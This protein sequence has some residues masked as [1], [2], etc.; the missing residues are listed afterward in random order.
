MVKKNLIVVFVVMMFFFSGCSPRGNLQD[1]YQNYIAPIKDSPI[2]FVN[3]SDDSIGFS[4]EQ[5]MSLFGYLGDFS[6]NGLKSRYVNDNGQEYYAVSFNDINDVITKYLNIDESVLKDKLAEYKI[7]N[8]D[9]YKYYGGLNSNSLNVIIKDSKI[10]GDVLTLYLNI[11]D[12]NESL[13]QKNELN[14][15][16]EGDN[17]FKYLSNKINSQ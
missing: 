13:V 6:I 3:F 11:Y 16:V 17:S 7:P 1:E 12:E 8:S 5:I 15:L 4:G 10:S 2:L 14:I 9:S